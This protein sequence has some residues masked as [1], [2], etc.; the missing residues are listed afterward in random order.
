MK[1]FFLNIISSFI[2]VF[3]ASFALSVVGIIFI[4]GLF[5][6]LVEE[7]EDDPSVASLEP[8]SVLVFALPYAIPEKTSDDPFDHYDFNTF[9][10]RI[11]LGLDDI[12]NGIYEAKDDPN[13]QGIY[14]RLSPHSQGWANTESI[15][16]ALLAF[17]ESGKWIMAYN[18]VY[19]HNTYY[20][21]SVADEIYLNP[22]GYLQ[23]QGLSSQSIYFK[24]SLEKLEIDM[25]VMRGP[26]NEYKSAIET[27][28]EDKMSESSRFQTLALVDEI[29]NHILNNISLSR[30][31]PVAILNE[32]AEQLSVNLAQDAVDLGLVDA[33]K[34]Q[35]EVRSLV[36]EK[37]SLNEDEDIAS[38]SIED[39]TIQRQS[40]Q[41]INQFTQNQ[42]K[43]TIAVIY[44]DGNI[45]SGESDDGVIG[46][47]TTSYSIR[48]AREDDNVKAIVLRVNSPG[49]GVLA[50]EVILR[51][52]IV[53]K[54]VKPVIVSFGNVAASGGYYIAS[55][56]DLIF[57]EPS[58]ITGSIGVYGFIPNYQGFLNNKLGI[59]FDSANTNTYSDFGSSTQ[60][61]RP[62]EQQ[63]I[64]VQLE[65]VYQTFLEHV[66]KGRSLSY[67][68]TESIAK[69]RVWS[70]M[71]AKKVGL[72][73]EFG[74]LREAID[75]AANM[76]QVTDYDL[77]KLPEEDSPFDRLIKNSDQR[78]QAWLASI[79]FDNHLFGDILKPVISH[80]N[81]INWLKNQKGIQAIM[82]YSLTIE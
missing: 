74:G 57:A 73:D 36:K 9:E 30:Q 53:T 65:S 6:T 4:I 21:S 31:V 15:R 68:E 20:I 77:W 54:D 82:P 59:T 24:N 66:A 72:V 61:I 80:Q 10:S 8:N 51:E 79:F 33:L 75:T 2:G 58:T 70:G 39:Y 42:S 1:S 76:A 37:L 47:A 50:S 12:I 67:E 49:G 56:A 35:D 55:A 34:Y 17:K 26:D 25:Q 48:Q 71:A 28:T 7:F 13:I 62:L 78:A 32:V 23:F 3:L 43:N 5:T 41:V 27:Y 46:S 38:I 29:W 19:S 60:A 45:Q 11:V 18:E 64:Q 52:L 22:E 69:G 16:R 44:A 81:E 40:K 14:L 63:R